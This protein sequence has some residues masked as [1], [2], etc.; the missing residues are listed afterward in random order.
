MVTVFVFTSIVWSFVRTENNRNTTT[1]H[2]DDVAMKGSI[3]TFTD[4]STN[5]RTLDLNLKLSNR[6][7]KL[8]AALSRGPSSSST[9]VRPPY[10][11][12]QDK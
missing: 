5:A 3:L 9:A 2:A 10:F 4:H 8:A 11:Q 1:I 6:S 12:G 7:S